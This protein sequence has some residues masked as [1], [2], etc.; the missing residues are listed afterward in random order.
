[1]IILHCL[2][3]VHHTLYTERTESKWAWPITPIGPNLKIRW[4]YAAW[5]SSGRCLLFFRLHIH[6]QE[7]RLEMHIGP[8]L[9]TPYMCCHY[10]L[11]IRFFRDGFYVVEYR[12]SR[13][14]TIQ[15]RR[16]HVVHLPNWED[17]YISHS[18][19]ALDGQSQLCNSRPYLIHEWNNQPLLMFDTLLISHLLCI[20]SN[21]APTW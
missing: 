4:V 5:L 8:G 9:P 16:Q 18:I 7:V 14:Q 1:M 3:G 20:H 11:S 2:F 12:A 19:Y 6:V 10:R 15:C 21:S 17:V 13:Y